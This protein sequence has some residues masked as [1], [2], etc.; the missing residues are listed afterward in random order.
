MQAAYLD[1]KGNVRM[2]IIVTH[3]LDENLLTW[4]HPPPRLDGSGWKPH[5]LD[6]L[7]IVQRD[8]AV[9][10]IMLVHQQLRDAQEA[11][12]EARWSPILEKLDIDVQRWLCTAT[13]KA[14]FA[15]IISCAMYNEPQFGYSPKVL[16]WAQVGVKEILVDKVRECAL[17]LPIAPLINQLTRY[18][19]RSSRTSAPTPL[20][21]SLPAQTSAHLL[22]LSLSLPSTA[23][24]RAA[25]TR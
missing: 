2:R 4:A 25:G 3:L 1:E 23:S 8:L 21:P 12:D 13:W 20:L 10:Q 14:V 9:L 7:A 22:S 11:G 15:G 18:R 6:N 16:A 5:Q 19:R 24:S 17:P